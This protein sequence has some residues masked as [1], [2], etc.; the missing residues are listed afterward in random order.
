[1]QPQ[2]DSTAVQQISSMINR[3]NNLIEDI[4]S[5]EKLQ[6]KKEM[7]IQQL[8]E[9]TA[10]EILDLKLKISDLN[11]KIDTAVKIKIALGREFKQIVKTD[12]FNRLSKRIDSLNYEKKLPRDEFNHLLER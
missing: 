1:M 4:L 10:N 2:T 6:E 8:K 3:H 5:L 7:E 11:K 12:S 9:I